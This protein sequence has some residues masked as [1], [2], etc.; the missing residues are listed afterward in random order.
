MDRCLVVDSSLG[1]T[2][3]PINVR[4]A[5][6]FDVPHHVFE[7]VLQFGDSLYSLD[8]DVYVLLEDAFELASLRIDDLMQLA[9]LAAQLCVHHGLQLLQLALDALFAVL[10]LSQSLTNLIHLIQVLES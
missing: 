4:M 8:I 3:E 6:V 2:F 7:V 10:E 1:H 5:L 9:L